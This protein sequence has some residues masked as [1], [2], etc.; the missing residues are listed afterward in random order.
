M[1]ESASMFLPNPHPTSRIRG[2]FVLPRYRRTTGTSSST[3]SRLPSSVLYI[4]FCALMSM[5]TNCTTLDP[6]RVSCRRASARITAMQPAI[7]F[8]QQPRGLVRVA[9]VHDYLVPDG[10]AERG[11]I[12]PP[13]I[14]PTPPPLPSFF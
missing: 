5:R 4:R 11:P 14:F 3:A 7:P 12:A 8:L 10:G 2:C 9:L 1:L 13:Q 6:C